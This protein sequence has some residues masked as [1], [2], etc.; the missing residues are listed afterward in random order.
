MDNTRIAQLRQQYPPH[1]K[2][3]LQ[4][5]HDPYAVPAG[6]IGTVT[7]VD[8]LGTIHVNWENGSTLGLIPDQDQFYKLT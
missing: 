6:T 4:A 5:M 8:D 1:T 7:S 3:K 2:I